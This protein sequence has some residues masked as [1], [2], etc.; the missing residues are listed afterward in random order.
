MAD[1]IDLIAINKKLEGI[2]TV[3]ESSLC[4]EAV[5]EIKHYIENNEPE[6]AFEGVFLELMQLN[7]MPA[8][9]NSDICLELALSLKLN[10]ETALSDK[11]W[12]RFIEF[13]K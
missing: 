3:C 9:L 8:G 1:D 2:L 11:F 7:R 5:V 13:L 4:T 6:I 12:Q 10:E